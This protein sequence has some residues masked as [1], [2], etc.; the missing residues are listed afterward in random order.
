ML[1]FQLST[2]RREDE[3]RI[4]Y[5]EEGTMSDTISSIEQKVQPLLPAL[6]AGSHQRV[7]YLNKVYK[8]EANV[9]YPRT[10]VQVSSIHKE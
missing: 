3:R 5:T 10:M 6:L 7:Q 1:T 4:R 8:R 2:D 9:L